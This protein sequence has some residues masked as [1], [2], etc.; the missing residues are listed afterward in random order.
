MQGGGAMELG[1]EERVEWHD[2]WLGVARF[3]VGTFALG[4]YAG[5]G[6][7]WVGPK[8]KLIGW[9]QFLAEV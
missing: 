8:C 7:Y 4:I 2:G 1:D 9:V 3:R 6:F 5:L